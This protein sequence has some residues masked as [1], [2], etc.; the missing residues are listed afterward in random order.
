MLIGIDVGTTAVKA[1][2]FDETGHALRLFGEAY[3]TS[4]PQSGHVEQ[5]PKIWMDLVT[6]A[7]F[8]LS[9]NASIKAIGLCSQVNT[10]VFVD[11]NLVVLRPAL[12]WQ[13][14]RCAADAALLDSKISIDD[15]IKWWGAPLPIDASH[16]LARMA[17]I[18]RTEPDLWARTH[19][20]LAPKDYCIAALTGEI[21][22]DPMTN[23]GILDQS[24][25]VIESLMA[26]LPGA[27]ERL[28]KIAPFTKQIGIIKQGFPCAGVPFVTGAM[29]AWSGLF[30]AGVSEEGQGL[31][32]SGTSEILGLI[33]SQKH[34][35]PGVIAFAPCEGLT[36]H[37]GPTQSGG[38]SA[39]WGAKLL[40][41][42]LPDFFSGA[43]QADLNHVPLFLPHLEGERAPLWDASAKGSFTGLTSATGPRELARAVLEGVAYSAR[44]VFESLEASGG[45]APSIIHH[46]GG[47]SR[48]DLWC[49]IR[50][51]VLGKALKRTATS[52]AGVLGAALM[53]GVGV[54]LFSSLAQATKDFVP[55]DRVFEP[56]INQSAYHHARYQAYQLA[57][58]QLKPINTLSTFAR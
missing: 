14:T 24:L 8:E 3:P 42:S 1:A 38:A 52:D 19:S 48:S 46:S 43:A 40:G 45:R 17:Y 21:V 50:S 51:D 29:D 57:Y 27:K 13:D 7:L 15:K 39:A 9:Q 55:F 34:P 20:V 22:S 31:Y 16:M 56:H 18:A 4:R 44:L 23:F 37:A 33:S 2:L 36:L 54:G 6:K 28:P 11:K 25:A 49:Q 5:D 47:G 35:T 53:A 26:L 58:Q 41:L 12:T 32:L 10:H 30:G